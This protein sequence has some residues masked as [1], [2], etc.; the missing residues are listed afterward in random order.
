[1]KGEV[2]GPSSR[3]SA[4]IRRFGRRQ[5]PVAMIEPVRQH[6]VDPEV[7][8]EGEHVGRIDIDRVPV[9]PLLTLGIDARPL[10]LRETR[11]LSEAAILLDRVGR[12]AP[13]PVV[14]QQYVPAGLID[15]HMARPRTLRGPFVQE[16]QL[17][18][19][20]VN[21]V[22]PYHSGLHGLEV[23]AHRVQAL[24]G[25]SD[26]QERR[27]IDRSGRT[28]M[29]KRSRRHIETVAIDTL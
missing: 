12:D 22:G 18:R 3:R 4:S 29:L 2:A 20:R 11:R 26:I 6:L 5:T 7:G 16:R 10:V 1:M 8:G 28:D 21:R 19:P 14:R 24:A 13:A 25:R 9:R 15:L 23:R 27:V 17:A